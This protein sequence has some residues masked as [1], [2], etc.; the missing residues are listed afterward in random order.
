[1]QRSLVGGKDHSEHPFREGRRIP[2]GLDQDAAGIAGSEKVEPRRDVQ[3]HAADAERNPALLIVEGLDKLLTPL[4]EPDIR[5]H[6]LERLRRA[7]HGGA[8]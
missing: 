1:M 2:P 8:G 5:K 3:V 7:G 6:L 4:V